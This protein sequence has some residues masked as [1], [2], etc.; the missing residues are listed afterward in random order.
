MIGL[1]YLL[2]I[3]SGSGINIARHNLKKYTP[4]AN[5]AVWVEWAK[6]LRTLAFTEW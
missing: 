5:V 1:F 6:V 2:L 4:V 3:G